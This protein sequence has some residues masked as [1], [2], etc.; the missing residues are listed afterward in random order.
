MLAETLL[1]MSGSVW[2]WLGALAV[3]FLLGD[4]IR[5]TVLRDRR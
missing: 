5:L 4:V 3:L 1:W 2:R